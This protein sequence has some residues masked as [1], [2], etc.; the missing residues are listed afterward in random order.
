MTKPMRLATI[1]LVIIVLLASCDSSESLSGLER[2]SRKPLQGTF[3]G[4]FFRSGPSALAT[5]SNVSLT[6]EGNEF[7]GQSDTPK[8]PGICHGTYTYSENTIVF[9]NKCF[10]TA[11][12]DWTLILGGEFNVEINGD[13]LILSKPFGEH[14]TDYYLLV[15]QP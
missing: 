11:E 1:Y 5:R 7:S 2:V 9:S 14:V 6:F 3:S 8:Y 12:F 4:Q 10:W 15:H 13:S